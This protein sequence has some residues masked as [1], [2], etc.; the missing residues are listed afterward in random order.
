MEQGVV[1]VEYSEINDRHVILK[2]SVCEAL[3]DNVVPAVLCFDL[4]PT[5]CEKGVF[6]A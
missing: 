3:Q 1:V 4:S 2:F 5:E 6:T